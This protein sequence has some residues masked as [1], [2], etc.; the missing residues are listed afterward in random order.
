MAPTVQGLRISLLRLVH[1]P[2]Q[3]RFQNETCE[4]CEIT[5]VVSIMRVCG[6]GDDDSFHRRIK[7]REH[8]EWRNVIV[9]SITEPCESLFKGTRIHETKRSNILNGNDFKSSQVRVDVSRHQSLILEYVPPVGLV[10]VVLTTP[11]SLLVRLVRGLLEASVSGLL[12]VT[13]ATPF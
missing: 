3:R 7:Q 13:V 2:H 8:I 6:H 1:E 4:S 9:L 12:T 11:S 10:T 5:R